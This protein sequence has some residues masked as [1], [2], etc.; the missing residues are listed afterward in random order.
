MEPR[1]VDWPG[2]KLHPWLHAKLRKPILGY[3]NFGNA[4]LLVLKNGR[5]YLSLDGTIWSFFALNWPNIKFDIEIHCHVGLQ[6]FISIARMNVNCFSFKMQTSLRCCVWQL[7]WQMTEYRMPV[8]CLN[9]ILSFEKFCKY[10]H[11]VNCEYDRRRKVLIKSKQDEL[12]NV[13]KCFCDNMN[14][15]LTATSMTFSLHTVGT[16]ILISWHITVLAGTSHSP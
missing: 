6:L 12:S 7:S 15:Y 8:R 11:H 2:M 16:L 13:S 9:K 4:I 10:N 3:P 14:W 5:E 1:R